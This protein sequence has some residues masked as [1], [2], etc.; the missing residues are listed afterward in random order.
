MG[1][2][3]KSGAERVAALRQRREALGMTR[4]ELF[5]HPEDHMP[6]KVYA[7][8]LQAARARTALNDS[9]RNKPA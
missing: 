9:S 7:L 6:I 2:T 5:A 8:S 1:V 3:A 4:L